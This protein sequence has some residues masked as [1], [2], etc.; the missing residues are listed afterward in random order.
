MKYVFLFTGLL[1]GAC[2]STQMNSQAAGLTEADESMVSKCQ[3][4]GTTMETVSAW[5]TG[6]TGSS[7][8]SAKAKALNS[9][10]AKGGTHYIWM[11][12]DRAGADGPSTVTVKA[13]TC[14][15]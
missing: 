13:Y 5:E 8:E 2:S 6:T 10:A 4:L 11:Q 15:S 12:L 7:F 3:F 1:L 9:A 14:G